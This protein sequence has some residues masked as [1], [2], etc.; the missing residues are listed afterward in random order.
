MEKMG[1]VMRMERKG[2]HALCFEGKERASARMDQRQKC[3][4][5]LLCPLPPL[6]IP[7]PLQGMLHS[8]YQLDP[9]LTLGP[10]THT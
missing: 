7:S 3:L 1:V 2:S 9:S 4:D 5:G 6:A 10:I 8:G